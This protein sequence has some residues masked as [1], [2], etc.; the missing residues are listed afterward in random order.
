MKDIFSASASAAGVFAGFMLAAA[1]ILASIGDR[2]FIRRA[3]RAGVYT[4]LIGFLFVAMR[5]SIATVALSI[6]ALILN[7]DWYLKWHAGAV[8]V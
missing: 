5:W 2:P 6:S 7:P 1:A 3:K 8:G 4:A